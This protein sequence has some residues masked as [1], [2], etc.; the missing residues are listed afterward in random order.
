MSYDII[1]HL[2]KYSE[3]SRYKKFSPISDFMRAEIIYNHGG[4]Y[5]DTNYFVFRKNALD[6]WLTF[7]GMFSTQI[8]P[9][10]RFQRE[11]GVFAAAKG[12]DRLKRLVDHRAIST[13]N[14]Y[15]KLM[16]I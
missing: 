14:I 6:D 10:H 12:F 15:S 4:I 16:H 2:L 9:Y 8:F 11:G 5:I 1:K 7:K 3:H 13:R